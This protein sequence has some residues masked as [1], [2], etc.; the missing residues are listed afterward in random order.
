MP[1][2]PIA[3]ISDIHGNLVALQAVLEAIQKKGITR[4]GCLGDIVGYG[5]RPVECLREV[6]RHCEFVLQGNHDLTAAEPV[7]EN[8]FIPNAREAIQWTRERILQ[9]SDGRELMETI[10]SRSG[11]IEIEDAQLMHAAPCN[12]VWK[13]I[14]P[15]EALHAGKMNEHFAGVRRIA[16]VGHTHMGGVFRRMRRNAYVFIPANS[17]AGPYYRRSDRKTIVNVGSVGQPRDNDTRACFVI[18]NRNRI[19]FC[20]VDYDVHS[21]LDDIQTMTGLPAHGGDR[22]LRGA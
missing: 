19:D 1:H 2:W 3:L 12:P 16:F 8:V 6:A 9:E 7:Y 11:S 14:M 20:R 4:I 15:E 17:L 21:V 5:P 18:W 10:E 13:Y 22:L